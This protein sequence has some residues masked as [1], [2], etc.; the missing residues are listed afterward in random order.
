MSTKI[1]QRDGIG[2]IV[3]TK[4][5]AQRAIRITINGNKVRVTQ[6]S[7][8]PFAAGEKFIND[9]LAWIKDHVKPTEALLEGALFGREHTL[10]FQKTDRSSIGSKNGLGE[11]TVLLPRSKYPED[12]DVQDYIHKKL[13]A[14]TRSDAESYLPTRVAELADMFGF[15]FK[16]VQ[17][18]Q[19]K[20]RWGSCNSKKELTFNLNLMTLDSL[21]I[22]YVILHELT[23][24]IHMN[25]GSEFWDH[26]ES[27][28]P[29]S[30]KIAKAVRHYSV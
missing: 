15:T 30:K 18:K 20:R 9:R 12:A 1:V 14:I 25:H 21:H 22:D 5:K 26:M 19:L 2:D 29:N 13:T 4:R 7:W 8:L 3:I 24:T 28:M 10:H 27:V 11:F 6:P 23:H 16:S 17:V